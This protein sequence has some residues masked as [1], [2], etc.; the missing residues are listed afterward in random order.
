MAGVLCRTSTAQLVDRASVSFTTGAVRARRRACPPTARRYSS[1]TAVG[2]SASRTTWPST[3]STATARRAPDTVPPCRRRANSLTAIRGRTRPVSDSVSVRAR[4]SPSYRRPHTTAGR[5]L[6]GGR[7]PP[8]APYRRAT[9]Q[10]PTVAIT[11]T[12]RPTSA[13][14]CD[15]VR[16]PTPPGDLRSCRP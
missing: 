3:A 10:P 12:R 4:V 15:C 6:A 1:S 14:R 8:T 16:R 7:R 11:T 5:P 2:E 9:L 13:P